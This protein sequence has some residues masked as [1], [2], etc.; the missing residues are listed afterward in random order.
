MIY[1]GWTEE[2]VKVWGHKLKDDHWKAA[3][4]PSWSVAVWFL[5]TRGVFFLLLK[6]F[7]KNTEPAKT[8]ENVDDQLQ[9][10]PKMS[11]T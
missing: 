11:W 1:E 6:L 10:N 4:L 5:M 9:A 7:Q 2:Q 8:S 3:R